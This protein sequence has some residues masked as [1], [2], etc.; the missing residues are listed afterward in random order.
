[1]GTATSRHSTRSASVSG[2]S[3]VGGGGLGMGGWRYE[4]LRNVLV[5]RAVPEGVIVESP[6]RQAKKAVQS[7]SRRTKKPAQSASRQT[8]KTAQSA[9]T[10]A[11]KSTQSARAHAKKPVSAAQGTAAKATATTA[12]AA[13][14]ATGVGKLLLGGL[15][16]RVALVGGVVVA[17]A[18][19][20]WAAGRRRA[21]H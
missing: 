1:M 14:K 12:R 18:A 8:R 15:V 21:K 9:T 7:A 2:P 19:G 20:A 6:T 11:R 16:R 5:C 3:I 17:G 10:R 13:V 4:D